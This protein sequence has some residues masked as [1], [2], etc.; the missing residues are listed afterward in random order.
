MV[1]D[2]Q[3]PRIIPF[4]L[5]AITVR[6]LNNMALAIAIYVGK[7]HFGIMSTLLNKAP[8]K[9]L[10]LV[11]LALKRQDKDTFD[12]RVQLHKF[13]CQDS[14]A[15]KIRNTLFEFR[16]SI[17]PSIWCHEQASNYIIDIAEAALTL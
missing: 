1:K 11:P 3:I 4:Y 10:K 7:L 8:F 14:A 2:K 16:A 5:K 12:Q 17:K 13:L 9:D 15:I 6:S